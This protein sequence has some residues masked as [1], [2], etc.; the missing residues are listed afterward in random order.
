MKNGRRKREKNV[1]LLSL[2]GCDEKGEKR[3]WGEGKGSIEATIHFPFN[4]KKKREMKMT[5]RR[6]LQNYPSLLYY[7][8]I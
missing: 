6:T 4:F 2:L 8:F 5:L 3:K 1:I 7:I